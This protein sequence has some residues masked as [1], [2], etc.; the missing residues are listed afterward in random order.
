M[1]HAS[2]LD[3]NQVYSTRIDGEF[4]RVC[5]WP[6]SFSGLSPVVGATVITVARG[7]SDD[8]EIS[9]LLERGGVA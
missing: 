7:L 1:T 2:E 9:L 6:I 5:C 3:N 8:L 4:R